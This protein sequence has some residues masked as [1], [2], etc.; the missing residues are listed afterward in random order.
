VVSSEVKGRYLGHPELRPFWQAVNDR[1]LTVFLHPEGVKDLWYQDYMLWNSVGQPLEETKAMC[2]MI[3]EGLFEQ[4]PNLKIVVS[5]G[6]G[7]LP[8]YTGRLDRNVRT[9]PQ[10]T[11]NIT[12]KP[13]DYLRNFYY[14]TC[15]YDPQ[16]LA[17]LIRRVGADRMVLGSDYPTGEVD[18]VGFVDASGMVSSAELAMISAGTAAK[19]LGIELPVARPVSA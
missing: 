1:D 15:V 4:F 16:I 6:G 12:R 7:Y 10:T 19:L 8:H 9:A 14:D 3:Y 18:P 5:H 13:S 11:K 17:A 2:S